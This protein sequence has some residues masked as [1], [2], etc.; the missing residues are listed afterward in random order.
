M[1]VRQHTYMY[2]YECSLTVKINAG[3]F[4]GYQFAN[5][6]SSSSYLQ[7]AFNRDPDLASLTHDYPL[8]NSNGRE[9]LLLSVLWMALAL[10]V[11]AFSLPSETHGRSIDQ[12]FHMQCASKK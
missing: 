3:S 6:S 9:E 5:E 7:N 11:K 12:S 8:D 1:S 10:S 4:I 2:I